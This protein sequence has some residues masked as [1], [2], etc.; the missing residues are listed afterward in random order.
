MVVVIGPPGWSTQRQRAYAISAM[1]T[2]QLYVFAMDHPRRVFGLLSRVFERSRQLEDG[3]VI[4]SLLEMP[5]PRV[6]MEW[7]LHDNDH[8]TQNAEPPW[9]KG[10]VVEAFA[11]RFVVELDNDLLR[12]RSIQRQTEVWLH[13]LLIAPEHTYHCMYH[14]T[15]MC[16]CASY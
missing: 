2:F 16:G 10:A 7:W 12:P 15:R 14:C 8:N 13:V 5:P 4:A 3:S 6:G 1:L 11:D 9:H